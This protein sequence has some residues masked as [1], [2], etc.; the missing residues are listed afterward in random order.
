MP[1]ELGDARY[2]LLKAVHDEHS[3]LRFI[4]AL[5]SGTQAD[6]KPRL[7]SEC[8]QS[9]PVDQSI[10]DFLSLASQWAKDSQFGRR[11]G[12]QPHNLW[13]QFALFLWSGRH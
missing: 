12:P 13:Q 4:D 3:F 1:K 5:A 2:S 9:I 6:E 8:H 11:P 10:S 7:A